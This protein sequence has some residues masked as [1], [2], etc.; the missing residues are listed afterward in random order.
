M[1][2]HVLIV[3]DEPDIAALVAYHL[4]KQGYRVSTA[5]NGTDALRLAIDER[6]D[7]VV[8]DLMLPP[9]SGFEVLEEL[10]RRPDTA[11]V[12]VILLTARTDKSDRLK[13]LS[14]GAD[15]Y[16]SKPFSPEELVLRV[17]AVLRRLRAPSV[18][19]S[20]LLV[21]GPLTIDP[22]A[23][24]VSVDG[25]DVPLTSTEFRLLLTLVQRRG[26]VQS[27]RRLLQDVWQANPD[28]QSR[29]VDMHVQRLRAKLG[30][31]GALIE[32]VRGAGYRFRSDAKSL[33]GTPT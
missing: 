6:P 18:S 13:G 10:R 8:L 2:D 12:G 14:L 19:G 20:S 25:S 21:A 16:V 27:R 31:P 15:D 22:D 9:R 23:H 5:S 29:T 26:R 30:A 28:I 24:H 7:V 4:A 33:Q 3:D 11:A 17:G 32:T 1:P